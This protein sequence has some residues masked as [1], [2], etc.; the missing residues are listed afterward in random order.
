MIAHFFDI[1]SRSKLYKLN[2]TKAPDAPGGAIY[3]LSRF[4]A[5]LPIHSTLNATR[6]VHLIDKYKKRERCGIRFFLSNR[7]IS[8]PLSA[9]AIGLTFAFISQ[10]FFRSALIGQNH[11]RFAIAT[12]FRRRINI[13]S[14]TTSNREFH[15]EQISRSPPNSHLLI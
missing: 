4:E 1:S 5:F 12:R 2:R 8:M 7:R 6:Q 11:F 13:V 10:S 9:S 3:A 15:S 14:N